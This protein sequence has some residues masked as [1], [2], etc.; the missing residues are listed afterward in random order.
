MFLLLFVIF[1]YFYFTT[2]LL[3]LSFSPAFGKILGEREPPA[4]P[5]HGR[6][7]LNL[8]ISYL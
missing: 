6:F 7:K 8:L 4:P 3:K 1:T 2:I 5:Y